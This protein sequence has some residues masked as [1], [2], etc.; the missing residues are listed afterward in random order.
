[1][2]GGGTSR[3]QREGA[4]RK[5]MSEK[6]NIKSLTSTV[7]PTAHPSPYLVDNM[8]KRNKEENKNAK[9]AKVQLWYHVLVRIQQQQTTMRILATTADTN[10]NS[11]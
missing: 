10:A 6:E 1:M 5:N 2:G 8:C 4:R 3:K 7:K 9:E 11:Y